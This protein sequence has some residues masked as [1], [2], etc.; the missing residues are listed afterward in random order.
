M[1]Q[2]SAV[3]YYGRG[4]REREQME[5]RLTVREPQPGLLLLAALL[6]QQQQSLEQERSLACDC[7]RLPLL[8]PICFA[9]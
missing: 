2:E 1:K 8:G 9:V 7:R 4:R 3:H 6:V 5:E